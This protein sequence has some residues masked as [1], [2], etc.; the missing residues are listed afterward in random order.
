M[1]KN[2][3]LKTRLMLSFAIVL[4]LTIVIST[5][6]L[7]GLKNA[8]SELDY[9]INHSLEADTAV[10]MCR[11]ETNVAARTLR[12]MAIDTNSSKI[13]DY[14]ANIESNISDLKTNLQKL[15]STYTGQDGLV[16]KYE[17]ALNE[18]L[19]VAYNIIDLLESGNRETAQSMIL[20]ECTPKLEELV[21]IAKELDTANEAI[22]AK[23][24]QTN[25]A[26][27]NSASLLVLAILIVSILLGIFISIKLTASIVKPVKEVENAAIQMS[28]GYL[29]T[30]ITNTSKDEVGHLAESM[31]SS[32]STLSM[33]ISDIDR[34][35]KEMASGNFN[36]KPSQPFI[37][38][39]KNI[40]TSITNFSLN[41]SGTL[42]SIQESSG[43]VDSAAEQVST[44]S[45]AL[46][47]GTTEQAGEVETL[48][49]SIAQIAAQ[50]KS[51]AKNAEVANQLAVHMAGEIASGDEKMQ[52]LVHAMGDI[53]NSSKE[54]GKIIKAIEDIAFQTNILALNAAVEAARAGEA[55]KGFA[56][57]ADEVRSL[58]AKSAEAAK[59][60][61]ELI[62]SSVSA[63]ANGTGLADDTAKALESVVESARE[64]T[65]LIGEISSASNEQ[66]TSSELITAGIDQI[67]A[68]IQTN[69]ATAE[70][71]AA[72]SEELSGQAQLLETLV[73][74][75]QLMD[76]SL[77]Q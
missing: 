26:E 55:G 29:N 9:F 42:R 19:A 16:E 20:T 46:A 76:T 38:D 59:N 47:Q 24:L 3:K 25:K 53:S 49:A 65:K 15:K 60:T 58:A 69:S 30:V 23:D 28:K 37:G 39:F 14:K 61:T 48:S 56:V 54:I 50:V 8:N 66:A 68:V 6:A 51:N 43:T 40:E 57:V 21:N 17:T 11:I 44:S 70:E 62:Q 31:R 64:I 32:M 72:A 2:L 22:Q 33:Y 35:M 4:V 71:S 45:Q 13:A 18:W 41:M 1:W 63:V 34:A 12:D 52:S 74:R 77:S 73:K 27:T 75:F 5:L 36:I 7:T 10:K 67:S